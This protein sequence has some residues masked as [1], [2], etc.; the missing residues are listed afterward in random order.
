VDGTESESMQRR[1]QLI[2]LALIATALLPF[3]RALRSD[4]G[5]GV[6]VRDHSPAQDITRW[7]SC[8]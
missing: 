4:I 6:D 3:A 1:V 2:F 5:S 8:S 7:A